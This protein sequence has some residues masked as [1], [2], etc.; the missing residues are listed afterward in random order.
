[1]KEEMTADMMMLVKEL[2]LLTK[3]FYS[4]VY[5]RLS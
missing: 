2:F 1:M 5:S 3:G 4:A